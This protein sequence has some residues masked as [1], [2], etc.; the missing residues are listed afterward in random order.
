[1]TRSAL[2]LAALACLLPACGR[3]AR[4]V[5][6]ELVQPSTPENLA[7][8]ATPDG[9]RL[10]WLRPT[11]YTGGHQMNDLGKFVI[12]RAAEGAPPRFTT[13][14]MLELTDQTRFR[15][16]RRLEWVDHDVP[17]GT[18]VLYRV[19]AV[20]LDGYQSAPAGP[21]ALTYGQPPAETGPPATDR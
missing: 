6:P 9:V 2:A 19:I 20:T 10:S 16:E 5:A 18:R 7:A 14:G 11:R 4:P 1:V 13:V 15:K 12:E 17:P 21:L 3:K 8:V